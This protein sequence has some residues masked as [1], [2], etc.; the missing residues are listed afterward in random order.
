MP[1]CYTRCGVC[2]SS[3]VR[4][5]FPSNERP[6]NKTVVIL[7]PG[8]SVTYDCL[9]LPIEELEVAAIDFSNVSLSCDMMKVVDTE[10]DRKDGGQ[11]KPKMIRSI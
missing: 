4:Q 9:S 7:E 3:N 6:L 5:M 11:G 2:C 1:K 8:F 10:N